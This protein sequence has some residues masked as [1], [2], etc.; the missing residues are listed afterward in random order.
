MSV[1]S[2][3]NAVPFFG[4]TAAGAADP[5]LEGTKLSQV[6]VFHL[7]DD[8]DYD[9]L[10]LRNAVGPSDIATILQVDGA[11]H[12]LKAKIGDMLKELL[13][14][15]A[16]KYELDA[17]FTHLDMD[18][19]AVMS[20][21]EFKAGIARLVA[22]SASDKQPV[23]T[24]SYATYR[25]DWLRHARVGYEPQQRY[26]EAITGNMDIGWHAHKPIPPQ[27]DKRA[28]LN[29]TDVTLLEGRTAVHYYGHFV[30]GQ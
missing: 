24:S 7:I 2:N 1:K 4:M 18:R 15:Q 8:R 6:Y 22:F 10:F 20:L 21:D 17:W 30:C 28:I 3:N 26:K 13:G 11:T 19:G 14:R 5:M 12:I 16:R 25:K 29:H 27:A 23:S 9:D